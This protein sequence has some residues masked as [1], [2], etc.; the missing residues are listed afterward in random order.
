[1]KT[2][3][4]RVRNTKTGQLFEVIPGSLLP[5]FFEEVPEGEL[6]KGIESVPIDVDIDKYTVG[7]PKVDFEIEEAKPEPKIVKKA[8]KTTK[9]TKTTKKGAKKDDSKKTK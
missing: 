1:M 9:K 5:D 6:P 8:K 3:V 4:S 7:E 2:T